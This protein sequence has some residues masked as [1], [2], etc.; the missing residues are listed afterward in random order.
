MHRDRLVVQTYD[1]RDGIQK[2]EAS[3]EATRA[4][5]RIRRLNAA[6]RERRED[7]VSE[8]ERAEPDKERDELHPSRPL[9]GGLSLV[10]FGRGRMRLVQ[11]RGRGSRLTGA[12][13]DESDLAAHEVP[14][15]ARR[16]PIDGVLA[17][18]EHTLDVRVH[19]VTGVSENATERDIAM[20]SNEPQR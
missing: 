18:R 14:V 6:R 12:F 2:K 17:G 11:H 5:G 16:L 15:G 9:I 7:P 19:A 8:T 3:P 4:I 20:W 1:G 10:R 13:D